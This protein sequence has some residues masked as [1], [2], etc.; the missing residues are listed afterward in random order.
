M[1]KSQTPVPVNVILSGNK[2][3]AD[4]QVKTRVGPNSRVGLGVSD[5]SL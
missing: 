5:F 4:D 2:V 3:F 1:L